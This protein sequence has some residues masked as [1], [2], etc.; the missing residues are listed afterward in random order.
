MMVTYLTAYLVAWLGV[1]AFVARL[2][3]RQKL[4]KQS[5]QELQERLAEAPI[6]EGDGHARRLEKVR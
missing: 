6:A 3:I 5:I 2:G 4:L 1:A